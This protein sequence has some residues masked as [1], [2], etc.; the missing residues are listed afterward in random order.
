MRRA[1]VIGAGL[2]GTVT[3]LC[4][5]DAGVHVDLYERNASP[6]LGASGV[7]EG[8]IHLGY[9]YAMDQSLKTAK[10][11]LRGAACFRT[12]LERWVGSA[13][14]ENHTSSSFSYA[15]PFSSMLDLDSIRAHF[16]RVS[17]LSQ[18]LGPHAMLA[19]ETEAREQSG[20]ELECAFDPEHVAASFKTNE[21]AIDP[22]AL[23]LALLSAVKDSKNIT[24]RYSTEISSIHEDGTGYLVAGKDAQGMVSESYNA[25]V[26]ATWH[27]RLK[28]DATFGIKRS[29][30]A[31]H[32]YKCGLRSTDP[33]VAKGLPSTTFIV[34]EYGDTVA[35]GD[36]A[37]VSWY[38]AGLISQEV[39]LSPAID[40]ILLSSTRRADLI[41]ST[42]YNLQKLL[43]G[44]SGS[45][46]AKPESW[47]IVGGYISAW[48]KTGINHADSKLHDRYE[49]GVHSDGGYHSIDTGKFTLAPL[50]ATEVASRI[51]E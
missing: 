49:V 10:T 4:L 42:L 30:D 1:A 36:N 5:S 29:Q 51:L 24:A 11:M 41:E 15:V 44:A 50:F 6:L 31:I 23:R 35:Y 19:R 16:A 18:N 34:G 45:L 39:G 9:V 28:L 17:M 40:D 14:F 12:I 48:G 22:W 7:N 38:P 25:V 46:S 3:A 37:F 32:R 20:R 21:I 2:T 26:N 43:P 47:E 33:S 13:V 27:Q 8:K